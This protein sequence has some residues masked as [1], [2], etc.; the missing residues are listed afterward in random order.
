VS[1]EL[2]I[3]GKDKRDSRSFSLNLTQTGE[4]LTKKALTL[5]EE[6]DQQ[7]FGSL[8]DKKK[9]FISLLQQIRK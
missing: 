4:L 1:K 3:K 8:K 7:Y 5:I 6:V 9:L 2:I